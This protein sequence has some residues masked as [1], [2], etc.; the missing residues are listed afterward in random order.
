MSSPGEELVDLYDPTDDAGRVTGRAPRREVRARNLPHAATGVLL[1]DGTPGG[2][3]RVLVH[4][5]TTTKDLNPGAHDCL[6][7][8]VVDA[9]EDP[10]DAAH[11]ELREEL[12]IDAELHPV[13]TRWY[14]DDTAHYL[15]HV[16]EARWDGR[17]LTL[18]PSEVAR[19]WWEDTATLRRRLEDPAWPFVPD[20]RALLAAWPGWWEDPHPDAAAGRTPSA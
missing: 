15:A 16:Y 3:G 14:R 5:R 13:L 6:A 9:G 17:P 8:G 20:T 1:R 19:A 11:R 12:G 7:G 2:R 10:L 18:Q 4:R